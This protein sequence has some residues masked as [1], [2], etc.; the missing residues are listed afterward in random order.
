MSGLAA[1]SGVHSP[2]D[3]SSAYSRCTGRIARSSSLSRSLQPTQ[4][5]K[6]FSQTSMPTP[7]SQ[8]LCSSS[9]WSRFQRRV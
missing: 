3:I 7:F 2:V 4:A 8:A 1:A 5:P 6:T 9:V